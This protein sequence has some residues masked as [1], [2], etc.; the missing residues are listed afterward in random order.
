MLASRASPPLGAL[1][2]AVPMSKPPGALAV[3]AYA[4]PSVFRRRAYVN[5][6]VLG[7]STSRVFKEV[8]LI[9][10]F[11]AG[12]KSIMLPSVAVM[13]PMLNFCT[14]PTVKNYPADTAKR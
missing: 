10:G 7:R 5:S 3:P 9:I 8:R 1:A 2:V 14:E 13:E 12:I 4:H 6:L 11:V